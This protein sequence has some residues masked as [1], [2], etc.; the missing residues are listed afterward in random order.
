M[1]LRYLT[2]FI[3]ALCFGATANATMVFEDDFDADVVGIPQPSLLNW[4]IN[5]GTVDVVGPAAFGF[6][7]D[8]GT[9]GNCLDLD[10]TPG[11]ATITTKLGLNLLAGD[12]AFSFDYGNNF[13]F[14][15]V[16]QWSIGSLAN[17]S[18]ASGGVPN[19]IYVNSLNTFSVGS[20]TNNVFIQFQ[21]FGTPDNGGTV[22]DNVTLEFLGA[23]AVPAPGVPALLGLA[24]VALGLRRS[25]SARD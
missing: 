8:N 16:L 1:S 4:N 21:Q 25:R 19:D 9:A 12:Y 11:N 24:L 17:G 13:G 10:G 15:N 22:L 5:S 6:L 7:C 20:D 14:D 3:I 2:T 23:A 18:V